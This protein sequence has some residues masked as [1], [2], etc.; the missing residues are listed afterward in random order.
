MRELTLLE[1]LGLVPAALSVKDF[2]ASFNTVSEYWFSS[3]AM[4]LTPANSGASSTVA[5]LTLKA[6]KVPLA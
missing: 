2:S 5:P 4:S 3:L 1:R 6:V